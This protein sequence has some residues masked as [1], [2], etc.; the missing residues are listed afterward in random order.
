M[1]GDYY[2]HIPLKESERERRE[3]A[4]LALFYMQLEVADLRRQ[5]AQLE[6]ALESERVWRSNR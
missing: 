1:S 5:I 2:T 3:E 6:S 4:E